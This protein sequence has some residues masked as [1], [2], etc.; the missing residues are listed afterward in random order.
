MSLGGLASA[1]E[2]FGAELS[3]TAFGCATLSQLLSSEFV[4]KEFVL[5]DETRLNKTPGFVCSQL[6]RWSL[7]PY[8]Q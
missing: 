6:T 2:R 5:R 8:S 7:A 3:E 4:Q 1:G